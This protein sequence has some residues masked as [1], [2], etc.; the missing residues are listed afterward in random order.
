MKKHDLTTSYMGLTF[1]NPLLAASSSLTIDTD[2]VRKLVD[3]GIG[4]IVLKSL[5]E[6]QIR[7][8]TGEMYAALEVD[9]H[10][11]ALE[12]LQAEL[13]MRLGPARYL[14]RLAEIKQAVDVPV[15]A[16]VNCTTPNEWPVF[17]HQLEAAGADGLEINVYDI[18]DDPDV[19]GSEMEERHIG[20]LK[21]VKE[22]VKIPVAVKIAPFY[23]SILNFI[24][25]L[26]QEKADAIVM[27]NRFFQPDIDIHQLQ[28]Q[29][30]LNLSHPNDLLLPLRW[31]SMARD[32]VDCD[33]SLTT[34]VH[35]ARGLIKALL[36][37]ANTVQIASVLYIN[38]VAV[39][40]SILD[41]L[42]KWMDPRG[43][44][45]IDDFRGLMS[46][47]RLT[48]QKG[49]ERAHYMKAL[50]STVY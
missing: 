42:S 34:G 10:P 14:E 47:S 23:S 28:L 19:T 29:S 17:A 12:Y 40:G 8:E 21:A 24:H 6:E 1:R 43:Y 50:V 26:E 45:K 7:A 9:T 48:D 4:G 18:P 44:T 27:L 39:I 20:M 2:K 22:V 33:L 32:V 3:A 13:P 5:F 11:E 41:G 15:I 35:D 30:S 46:S 49:F 31:I 25:R 36:A 38:D 37:G 16:S